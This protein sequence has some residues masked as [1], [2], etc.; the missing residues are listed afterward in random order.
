MLLMGGLE[1]AMTEAL[2][3]M[4]KMNIATVLNLKRDLSLSVSVSSYSD[5][6]LQYA[7]IVP[8]RDW[9]QR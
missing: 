7:G 5:E 1:E 2:I 8:Q 6:W 4:L 3:L 9:S